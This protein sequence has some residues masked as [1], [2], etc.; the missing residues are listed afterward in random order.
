VSVNYDRFVNWSAR[1]AGEMPFIE[2]NLQA[3][4]AQRVVDA[5]CGTGM[6]AIALA[7]RGYEVVGAD[8][9]SGM[10]GRARLN[11]GDAGGGV[12]FVQAGFGALTSAVGGGF[13]AVL[14]LGN[15]LPHVTGREGLTSALADFAGVLRGGGLLLIQNR[16]FDAVLASGERW[17]EP[18][19]Q[20]EGDDEW[21][22]LRFYDFEE[23]GTLH[24]NF[25]TLHRHAE[26]PWRQAVQSS[27]LLPLSQEELAAAL[28]EVGF[29]DVRWFGSLQGEAFDRLGSPNLVLVAR[30]A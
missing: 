28:G 2:S 25:V 24:F 22:F 13:D 29:G 1:L 21:V 3:V 16:N 27:R 26:G 11:A 14:C 30:R 15:S 6:H 12:R 7:Q 9:S 10:I 17:M 8:V 18:Q 23:D 20:L 5:A 19:S 4:G